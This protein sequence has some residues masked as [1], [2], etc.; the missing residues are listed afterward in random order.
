MR[1]KI[2]YATLVLLGS[3]VMAA[4][5]SYGP[6]N[7]GTGAPGEGLCTDCHSGPPSNSGD[8]SLSLQGITTE[9]ESGSTYSMTMTLSDPG[10]SRWGFELV[11]KD[12]SDQQVGTITVTDAVNTKVSATGSIIYLKQTSAGSFAGTAN[13]PVSWNFDWIAPSSGTG[14]VYFY[15]A[16]CAANNDSLDAGD[17]TYNISKE[18]QERSKTP[19]LTPWGAIVL[20]I[21]V[22]GAGIW[23][24]LKRRSTIRN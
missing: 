22:A 24:W 14:T 4:A 2:A 11:V 15:V 20:T 9:Y 6:P 3:A 23:L 17:Y 16:G 18:V 7:G 19:A 8:G 5:F 10:Q 1:F 13:G 12:A 21:L